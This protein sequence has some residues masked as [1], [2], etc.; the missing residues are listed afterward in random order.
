MGYIG[1]YKSSIGII[2]NEKGKSME[3]EMK[4]S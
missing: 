2:E 1:F 3:H 4:I